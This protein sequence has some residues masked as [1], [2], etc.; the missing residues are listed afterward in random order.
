M[1]CSYIIILLKF[2]YITAHQWKKEMRERKNVYLSHINTYNFLWSCES[3]S[4]FLWEA[5]KLVAVDVVAVGAAAAAAATAIEQIIYLNNL[6][7]NIVFI[8]FS[9]S[10]CLPIFFVSVFVL[11]AHTMHAQSHNHYSRLLCHADGRSRLVR[12]YTIHK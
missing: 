5:I 2:H 1:R 11:D 7:F 12:K 9:R 10:C 8:F 4:R 6:L 3:S